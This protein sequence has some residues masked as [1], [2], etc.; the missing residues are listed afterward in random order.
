[1]NIE[2]GE[3]LSERL[4]EDLM[5]LWRILRGVTNPMK[6]GEITPQQYW[7]L[8]QLWREGPMSIGEIA[9]SL[10]ITQG[11]ATSACQRLERAG[12]VRRERQ[13]ED[14][15]VVLVEL[16]EKGREQYEGWKRRRREVLSGLVSVLDEGEKRELSRLIERVLEAAEERVEEDRR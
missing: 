6:R 2:G 11:S 16:T 9:R 8:R 3:A 13:A 7:L 12:M 5:S 15:R 10:G 1:M 4:V 14:E